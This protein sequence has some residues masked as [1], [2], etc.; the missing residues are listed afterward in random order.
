MRGHAPE[1]RIG[2][3]PALHIGTGAPHWALRTAVRD[4]LDAAGSAGRRAVACSHRTAAR[5]RR[6]GRTTGFRQAADRA[7]RERSGGGV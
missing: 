1:R 3:A 2:R 6:A 5:G 4:F 7:A